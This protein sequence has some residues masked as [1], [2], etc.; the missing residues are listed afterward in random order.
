VAFPSPNEV[1]S[2]GIL[3]SSGSGSS[4]V[5]ASLVPRYILNM[6]TRETA[7][8][9]DKVQDLQKRAVDTVKNIT[10]ATDD[11]V[12]DNTWATIGCAALVGCIVGFI[13]AGRRD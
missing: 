10:E 5:S 1:S 9:T 13:L 2:G 4:P 12:R 8:L 6:K 3:H 7:D 11:Y